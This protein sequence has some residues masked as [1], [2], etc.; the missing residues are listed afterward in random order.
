MISTACFSASSNDEAFLMAS[1]TSCSAFSRRKADFRARSVFHGFSSSRVDAMFTSI[2]SFLA[3][4]VS[5]V[6]RPPSLEGAAAVH[7]NRLARRV[8]RGGQE[9]H[10]LHDLRARAEAPLRDA[11][12]HG[13]PRPRR[14]EDP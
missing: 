13:R 3:M 12:P 10:G 7:S 1:S 4:K 8:L 9:Q 11:P 2:V 6:P 5:S 14:V